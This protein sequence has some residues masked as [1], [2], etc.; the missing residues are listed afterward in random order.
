MF[1]LLLFLAFHSYFACDKLR[2]AIL[3]FTLQ[4]GNL[5]TSAFM[6]EER[7]LKQADEETK[8]EDE[9]V[10]VVEGD[11]RKSSAR[12]RRH[13]PTAMNAW[14]SE[15]GGKNKEPGSGGVG[16]VAAKVRKEEDFSGE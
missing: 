2:H 11:E 10:V 16:G 6:E 14:Y 15:L 12:K 3:S 5:V 1:L 4:E 13:S 8:D 9:E 7:E